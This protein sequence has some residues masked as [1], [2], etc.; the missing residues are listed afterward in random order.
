VAVAFSGTTTFAAGNREL[1]VLNFSAA[2]TATGAVIGFGSTP[3]VQEVV[4]NLASELTVTYVPATVAT[5]AAA[6][7]PSITAQPI[8]QTVTAGSP[9]T[10]SVTATG[11]PAPTFQ[12][13]KGDVAISGATNASY[14]IQSVATSDAGSYSVTATST[15]G[16]VTS[17]AATLSVNVPPSITTAPVSQ[18]ATAGTGVTFTAVVAGTP[19]PTYQWSK[20]GV[21]INGATNASFAIAAVAVGDAGSYTV[22]ATNAAGNVTSSAATLTVNVLPVI[23][24]Q[25]A[26]QTVTVGSSVTFTA[27]A[28]GT[29]A[30]TFVWSKGGV[31]INGATSATY[32]IASVATSDAGTYT[33]KATNAAGNVASNP[34]TL[35]VNVPAAIT[36]QPSANATYVVGNTLSLSVGATGTPTP[37]Y[38]WR[39][40]GT[41]I[42]G[43]TNASFSIATLGL[44]D[45]GTYDVVVT[46]SAGTAT[47][48]AVTF[49]VNQGPVITTQ[50]AAQT[51]GAGGN[52]TFSV[53]ATG[54][55]A[56]TYQ[57]SKGGS[58]ISG[59]T[60]ASYTI[61]SITTN[62]AGSY[63]VTVA[64]SVATVT[65]SAATL[66]V[67]TGPAIATHP[68]SQTV[69][70]NGNVS[71]NVV[72]SGNP[73]PTYQWRKAGTNISGATNAT[74]TITGVTQASAGSYDVVVSNSVGN[75]TSDAATLTVNTPPAILTQS[76]AGTPSLVGSNLTITVTTS[77][78]PTP[79]YQWKKNNVAINGAT[80]A[81]L[82]F[83][84]MTLADAAAYTV[85]ATNSLG[86]AESSPYNLVVYQ[87]PAI[88]TQP[89]SQTISAGASV[90]FTAAASGT[91]A[92][93]YQWK[94]GSTAINGATNA[95]YTITTVA[96]ADAGSYSVVAT[97]A[98]GSATSDAATLTVNTGPVI[99]TQPT[100]AA[101]YLVGGSVTLSVVASGSPAPT[102]QWRKAGTAL[103]GATNAS[104]TIASLA[105]ADA[106]SYDVVLTNLVG[107][108]TSNAVSLV[109]NQAPA[110]TTQPTSQTVTAGGNVTFSVVATGTP[111]PTFQWKKGSTAIAAAT[112]ASYSIPAVAVADG[113]S[114]S[115]VVTNVAGSVTSDAVTLTVNTAPVITT[116]PSANASYL[117]G[118]AVTLTVVANGNPTP[119]YQW[120]KG[121]VA[122]AGKTTASLALPSLTLA[123]A[124]SYDVVVANSVST[125]TSNA[126]SFLVYQPPTITT[127]PSAQTVV[128]G[129]TATFS[130]VVAGDPA[131]T[132]QWRRNGLNIPGATAS[133]LAL[134]NVTFDQAG[135]YTVYVANAGGAVTSSGASL[136]VNPIAPVI[137]SPSS[138]LGVRGLPLSY[139]IT[140][141]ATAATFTASGLPVGLSL[142]TQTGLISGLPT[143]TGTSSATIVASNVTGSDTKVVSFV[144]NP[145]AP[146][147]SSAVAA[148]GRVS[149]LFNFRLAASNTPTSFSAAD[150]PPGLSLASATGVISGTPTQAGVYDVIVTATNAGGT[151]SSTLQITIEPPLNAPTFTGSTALSA[152]QGVA[153]SFTPAFSGAPFTAAFTATGLPAGITLSSAS[154]GTISGTP[155]VTGTFAVTLTATNAGG[156]KSIEFALVVNPAPSAPVVKSASAVFASVG[157]AFS[158]S[159]T[160]QG[161][162]A[163]TSY[164]A[165]VLPSNGLSLNSATGVISGTPTQPG[166]L[167]LQVSAANGVGSGPASALVITINPSPLAPVISS[168]P[169]AT[170][171]V[172]VAFNYQLTASNSPTSFLQTVGT[173]PAGL[174]VNLTTGLI[175]GT[176]TEAGEK[177]VWFAGDS[178]TNGRGFAMEVTF[179]I[180]PAATA[181]V[182]NSNG[183]IAGQVGLPF[184]YQIS[185]TNTPDSF[186]ASTLPDGLSLSPASGLISGIPTKA[187]VYSV[188]LTAIKGTAT[189]DAKTLA[190]TIQ[191]APATPVIT[192][193]LSALGRAGTSFSYTATASESPTSY[194][195]SGLPTGLSMASATGVIS[196]TPTVSGTFTVT[197]R[198][199]NAAGLGA[200]SKLVIALGAALNAPVITSAPSVTGKVGSATAISYQT[201]A[202][203]G[204]ITAYALS[205]K[206]PLGLIFNTSTGLLSG[207][208]A[209]AGV[210]S[211]KLTAT[212][213]G[214]VSNPQELVIN[215][216]PSD[217]VPVIT[218]PTTAYGTVGTAFTYTI[219]A[220]ASPP[221]PAAPF[222]APFLLDAI[223][224]PVGLA[225]NPSTG[226]IQGTPTTAGTYSTFLVGSNAA[227]T[228]QA[229]LL[230]IVI[231]P[232]PTAPIVT[233]VS[234]VSAQAGA[235]F[236]Y[237]IT[238]TEKPTSYEVLGAPA[239]M[240]VNSKTGLISG[241]PSSPG[242]V[243]VDLIAKNDSGASKPMKLTLGIAAAQL[244]PVITSPREAKG[245]VQVAFRYEI[246]TFVPTGGG[247][248]VGYLATGLPAGLSIDSA[249][250]VISGTPL[251]S[252]NYSVLIVAKN[253]AGESLP[254]AV[255]LSIDPNL[256]FNF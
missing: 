98:A 68:A 1:V 5:T 73:A 66:T 19:A 193:P 67:N 183:S 60:S 192:S 39:K 254:V 63:T 223:A 113:A 32:T 199:A 191:P 239:W 161:T 100:A 48:N 90:T 142:N 46:N 225:V 236:S 235:S 27:A 160:S 84:S 51:M 249:T 188:T 35:T 2:S 70:I 218:S 229:R 213:E 166:T 13:K 137:T 56:P 251:A 158:F 150:L 149:T 176:P 72:A 169:L 131:P 198:A 71:F 79:T 130:V 44:T 132:L 47:S 116:Q 241:V 128:A 134:S 29:P 122:I 3:V 55:P 133:T 86:T 143:G 168:M 146:V 104:F 9:V 238:A 28:S 108:T 165:T 16:T 89:I 118:N 243:A 59:A 138:A 85:V 220:S 253:V 109:V 195:A 182:V 201:V 164:Q 83:T 111:A 250:G 124:G 7:I 230:T 30:P 175:S 163:A 204:P 42:S 82:T 156:S 80:N 74:Y 106:G 153:F 244:A 34:A 170:G 139:Q 159:L 179:R 125:V 215:V 10:F 41:N 77:G 69:A 97:N 22:T 112:N 129:T 256:T 92:P 40:A 121:G 205:G 62:D 58:A 26:S 212:N 105:L 190:I 209:A 255:S 50:P 194:V 107:T 78:S 115:V 252:G 4:D 144:I 157:T 171:Q 231:E 24:T 167:T 197:L 126:V 147:V 184:Q 64:N 237:Q 203:P 155:T 20:G 17:T 61:S 151:G 196:G 145:P 93:T 246:T 43:A 245:T 210:F 189:S 224:L 174:S 186:A 242:A 172:G 103:N 31:A 208:P 232:A 148:A 101:S 187:G 141:T 120:R 54:T 127:Q 8:S 102:Y 75:V 152:V 222:P 178:T 181:P 206:L 119:T 140:T 38:Q 180:A 136:T 36:T 234:A 221:F 99:A 117:V 162:P 81:S 135:S 247:A 33:V 94:K 25:P 95:S 14:T 45:A 227:G 21:A 6:V 240:A 173:L 96:T 91:P 217:N 202:A 207:N 185:A 214:G 37:T 57:W 88:I 18:T 114:Y 154:L 52:V 248:V 87:A 123:D 219:S 177:R 11:T 49:A 228:G 200:D 65:S 15:A 226:L 216:A 23:T 211:V 76:A 12:W 53:A 233:S 110:I